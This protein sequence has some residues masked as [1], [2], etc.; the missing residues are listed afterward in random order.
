MAS[1]RAGLGELNQQTK[2]LHD[3]TTHPSLNAD[4]AVA[5]RV[6]P[7]LLGTHNPENNGGVH[8]TEVFGPIATLRPYRNPAHA[9]AIMR[10]GRGSLVALFDG[11]DPQTLAAASLQSA[12][13]HD[14]V[15]VISPDVAQLH[16]AHGKVR[17][18]SLHGGPDRAGSGEELGGQRALGFYHRRSAV[19]ASTVV[20]AALSA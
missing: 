17:P 16:T 6:S 13:S 15:H 3:G 10:R 12:N 18:Q 1:V 11:S 2:T 20:L 14:R 19:Q 7:T 4:L 5:R 9:L 8:D